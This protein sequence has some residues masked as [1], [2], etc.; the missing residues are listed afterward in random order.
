VLEEFL[1]EGADG[2]RKSFWLLSV[3]CPLPVVS[4]GFLLIEFPLAGRVA[5][6]VSGQVADVPYPT[7]STMFEALQEEFDVD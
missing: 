2:E 4:S 7:L 6:D 1:K 3:S 5:G